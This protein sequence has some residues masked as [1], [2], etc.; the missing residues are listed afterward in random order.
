[1]L[2]IKIPYFLFLKTENEKIIII[3]C[4]FMF[5]FKTNSSPLK[6]LLF[7]FKM[8]FLIYFY[9]FENGKMSPKTVT[10]EA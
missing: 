7:G 3:Q 8:Y 2:K 5:F 1:M 6:L 10:E 9:F 4:V